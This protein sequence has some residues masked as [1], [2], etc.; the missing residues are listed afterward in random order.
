MHVMITGWGISGRTMSFYSAVGFRLS[1]APISSYVEDE[2]YDLQMECI[3][4]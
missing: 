4:K 3:I 1:S 2:P